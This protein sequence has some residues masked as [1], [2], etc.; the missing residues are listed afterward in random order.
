MGRI[1]RPVAAVHSQIMLNQTALTSTWRMNK[2]VQKLVSAIDL[3][4]TLI[5]MA[6]RPL[7]AMC[8]WVMW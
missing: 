8:L 4:G 3:S 6:D 5:E 7:I 2:C 1:E